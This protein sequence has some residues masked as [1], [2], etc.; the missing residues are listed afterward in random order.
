VYQ[1][2]HAVGAIVSR[3]EPATLAMRPYERL[4]SNC[5][6]DAGCAG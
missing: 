4:R 5:Q 1:L 2:A 3:A 6:R